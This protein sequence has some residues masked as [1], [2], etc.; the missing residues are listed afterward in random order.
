M[1]MTDPPEDWRKV[2]RRVRRRGKLQRLRRWIA[3][4]LLIAVIA[5]LAVLG[6]TVGVTAGLSSPGSSPACQKAFV[7][8][9]FPAADWPQV[10]AS[11]PAPS[12]MILNP[13]TGV[14][15]GS[16]P[17]PAF[18]AAVRQAR[19]AGAAV[20]GYSST[21]D[22]QRPAAEIEA[23]IRNYKSWY[24]VTGIFL[25]SVNGVSSELPYYQQLAS[26]A[27]SVIPGSSVWLN[28]GIYPDPRYMS[29]GNVLMVFEGTYD[30]YLNIQV[31]AW[32]RDFPATR[33]AHTIYG[34]TSGSQ[35]D[36]VIALARSRNAGFVYVTNLSGANPY[37]ALPSYWSSANSA[38]SAGCGR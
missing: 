30:Q 16:A 26:Y 24:G 8:A 33:F 23:D 22:G 32:A 37:A 25:D 3:S 9:Y 15:A 20:L 1:P 18:Q 38:I 12:V 6:L 21:A 35:A 5:I 7:P 27:H 14:G 13:A 31:P 11:K 34:V 36:S 29:V 28:A 17:D 2:R 4:P 19:A 10:L